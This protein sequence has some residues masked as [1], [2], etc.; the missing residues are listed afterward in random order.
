MSSKKKEKKQLRVVGLSIGSSQFTETTLPLLRAFGDRFT[1]IK[2][3]RKRCVFRASKQ[4]CLSIKF[5]AD[6]KRCKLSE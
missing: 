3:L 1:N 2:T 4:V 5:T 6:F